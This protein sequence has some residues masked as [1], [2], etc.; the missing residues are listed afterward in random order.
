MVNRNKN[1]CSILQKL[2]IKTFY[3]MNNQEETNTAGGGASANEP[4]ASYIAFCEANDINLKTRVSNMFRHYSNYAWKH[5]STNDMVSNTIRTRTGSDRLY[6]IEKLLM[7]PDKLNIDEIFLMNFKE[8]INQID[9]MNLFFNIGW[10]LPTTLFS[11]VVDYLKTTNLE[12]LQLI[13]NN[14]WPLNFICNMIPMQDFEDINVIYFL[15]DSQP[16]NLQGLKQTRTIDE[17]KI[18]IEKATVVNNDSFFQLYLA[19]ML[20]ELYCEDLIEKGA[21]VMHR[22]FHWDLLST[23]FNTE[24]LDKIVHLFNVTES[25]ENYIRNGTV[26]I[27]G[28]KYFIEKGAVIKNNARI[29]HNARR[30]NNEIYSFLLENG[31]SVDTGSASIA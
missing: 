3:K 6:I 25:L 19:N 9:L 10:K 20:P 28:I 18:M 12:F 1:T 14:G 24:K 23:L 17:V 31:L 7:Y 21:E 16:L 4:S 11:L 13:I 26:T 8:V 27:D 30:L 29:F 22:I 15:L 2:V 5:L